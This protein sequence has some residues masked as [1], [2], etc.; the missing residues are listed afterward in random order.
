[1]IY[2]RRVSPLHAARP[3]AGIVWC[4]GLAVAALILSNP[5]VLAAVL[6]AALGG[7]VAARV[8]RELRRAL[9]LAVPLALTVVL[10]NALVTRNGL[11]VIWRFG[12]L[13]VL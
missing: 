2:R 11:T 10:I 5:L 3:A 4:A 9:W 8:G 12:N 13:P 7:G 6:A 1:M